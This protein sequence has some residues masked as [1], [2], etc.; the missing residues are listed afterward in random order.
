MFRIYAL[1]TGAMLIAGTYIKIRII[2]YLLNKATSA[3]RNSFGYQIIRID[4][5]IF[6]E[7]AVTFLS[8]P[9]ILMQ[10]IR[11]LFPVMKE[12]LGNVVFSAIMETLAAF[13]LVHRA[14]GGL[15]I[16]AVRQVQSTYKYSQ[17]HAAL[18]NSN[19]FVSFPPGYFASNFIILLFAL[20]QEDWCI[21]FVALL[22]PCL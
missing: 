4:D 22:F 16:A 13:A 19:D 20:E 21:V 3:K 5:L 9:L 12:L 8:T 15:G 6:F 17:P 11:I 10:L 18:N 7:E 2:Q 14:M 1:P